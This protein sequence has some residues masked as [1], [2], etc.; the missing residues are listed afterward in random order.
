MKCTAHLLGLDWEC[1]DDDCSNDESSG[2]ELQSSDS[3]LGDGVDASNSD[4]SLSTLEDDEEIEER[5]TYKDDSSLRDQQSTGRKRAARWFPLDESAACEWRGMKN[6]GGGDHPIV[7]CVSGLQEN[8]HHGS[9]KNTLNN[10]IGNVHRICRF[11]HARWHVMNDEGY[12]WGGYHKPHNPQSA[13]NQELID[14]ENYWSKRGPLEDVK[15]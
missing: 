7:G 6:C 14:N 12:V 9:D 8:R 13:T 3:L 4:D 2:T 11:C 5:R 10:E 1:R 15:D